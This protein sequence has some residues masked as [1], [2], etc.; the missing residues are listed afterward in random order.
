VISEAVFLQ[1]TLMVNRSALA[2]VFSLPA[3]IDVTAREWRSGFNAR[4]MESSSSSYIQYGV[5]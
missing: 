1:L 2:G 4:V 5:E 3:S